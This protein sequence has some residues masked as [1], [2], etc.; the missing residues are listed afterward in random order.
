METPEFFRKQG[1]ALF[2]ERRYST[3]FVYHNGADSYYGVRGWRGI[4]R[5]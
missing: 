2:A 3:V 5:I 4:L 1:G